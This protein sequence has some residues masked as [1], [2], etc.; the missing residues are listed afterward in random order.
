ML[1][2]TLTPEKLADHIRTATED[3]TLETLMGEDFRVFLWA[4]W[5]E[6]NLPFPTLIQLDIADYLQRGPRRRM[7]QAFRG[8]GKSWITAAFVLWR[9]WKEPN[10]RILVVSASK[11]RSDAFSLFCKRLIY[12][13]EWLQHLRPDPSK[14]QRDS[15]VAFDVGPSDPH[16]APSV[17]SVG[18]S[19][20]LTGG[21]ASLIIADDVEVPKNALTVTQRD[22]LAE[23]VKEFDAVLMSAQ[24]L[25]AMG[26]EETS[27]I[28][29]LGTPQTIMSLYNAL[30]ARGY[31]VRIW[32]ARYP[33]ERL[34]R[35]YSGRL[36]PIIEAQLRLDPGLS[37]KHGPEHGAPTD[38]GRFDHLDLVEREASYSR[39]G[40]ALQFQLDTSLSDANKYPLKL[41]DLLVMDLS[42]GLAPIQ[43]AWGS[44]PEQIYPGPEQ[45]G[46]LPVVGLPGDRLHR[47]MFTHK[48]FTPFTGVAMAIDPS[49]RGGDE[50]GYAVVAMLHGM[51]FCLAM[52]GLP[53]GYSPET[54][55]QLA[56]IAK[57]WKVTWITI[58]P[59]FGDGMFDRLFAPHLLQVGYPCTIDP[60]PPRSS[61]QKERRIIDV[62]EPVLNQHR[63][64][65]NTSVLREDAKTEQVEYQGFYQMTRLTRDKGCL[66]RYDRL[67]AL[68]MA[69][70][71][72][73]EVMDVHGTESVK[74]YQDD[75]IT[76][77][78]QEF[79]EN[80]FGR[81][82]SGSQSW[83]AYILGNS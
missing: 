71:Y 54:L 53:G 17:R 79:E 6:L 34:Q 25:K 74:Q 42:S 51:L 48:D 82:S 73:T 68:A 59:N 37:T 26:R 64:V 30:P 13:I 10:E 41:A 19:G 23:S 56:K 72:W 16:Q 76:K 1:T 47:P 22:K 20:Q 80:V 78:L 60:D 67:D 81:S 32:P 40:F 77:A 58:E 35:A 83:N 12:D 29:Y 44:G 43:M 46:G 11:D 63:L 18:I 38:P 21:R 36:A 33:G 15:L 39:S 62:L 3:D 65:M 8:V 14:E 57:Q 75:Q 61:I 66:T 9:L 50:T 52:G 69:V 2:I 4:I 70:H 7:V 31:E 55:T 28:I 27:E 49:G 5:T 24:D 45:P